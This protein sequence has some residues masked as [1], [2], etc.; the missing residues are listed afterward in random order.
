MCAH[1]RKPVR[2]HTSQRP[3]VEILRREQ[4]VNMPDSNNHHN[5]CVSGAYQQD[6]RTDLVRALH[7]PKGSK[8]AR[9]YELKRNMVSDGKELQ[10]GDRLVPS[11]GLQDVF[12]IRTKILPMNVVFWR[13][14][15]VGVVLQDSVVNRVPLF[16]PSLGISPQETMAI[17]ALHTVY[18]GPVQRWGSATLWRLAL[19]NPWVLRVDSWQFWSRLQKL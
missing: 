12:E 17:D 11:S 19:S 5:D 1:A 9:G 18:Y 6:Q 13:P 16:H 14:T 4:T 7:V 3:D 15:Y 10:Q 8:T 2:T